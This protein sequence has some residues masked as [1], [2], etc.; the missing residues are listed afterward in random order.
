MERQLKALYY[1]L[2]VSK[3]KEDIA[4]LEN[5]LMNKINEKDFFD[6]N[7]K[8]NLQTTAIKNIREMVDRVQ[9]MSTKNSKDLNFFLRKLESVTASMFAFKTALDT[10]SGV[11][12]E[13]VFDPNKYLEVATFNEFIKSYKK[14]FDKADKNVDDIRRLM[15]DMVE[16]INTKITGED[17]KSFENLINNK[18]EELK[19]ICVRKFADKIDTFKNFKYVDAQ[20]KHITQIVLKRNDKNESW[21]IAKK[22][23]G[24]YSCASCE[25]YIGELREKVDFMAWN[26]YPNRDK[27]KGYRIGNGFSH[28]L[29]MLNVDLK[30]QENTYKENNYESDDEMHRTLMGPNGTSHQLK[31]TNKNNMMNT[32]GVNGFNRSNMLP[33]ILSIKNEENPNNMTADN[34]ERNIEPT[35]QRAGNLNLVDENSNPPIDTKQPHIVKVYRKNKYSAPDITRI[36]K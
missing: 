17:L 5:E 6:L 24:G 32:A 15:S 31:S 9:D 13:N 30:N 14:D 21:L 22:P 2:D 35:I 25:A 18:L 1:G 20:M 23:M 34:L 33:K 11:K 7:D 10:L 28:M 3:T 27:D 26:K 36:E 12:N 16:A 4:K 19:L 29:N 8:V